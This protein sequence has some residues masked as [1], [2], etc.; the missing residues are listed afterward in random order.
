MPGLASALHAAGATDHAVRLTAATESLRQRTGHWHL[1][2]ARRHLHQRTI[3][4]ARRNLGDDR[5]RQ[6]W[7][8][9]AELTYQELIHASTASAGS[10]TP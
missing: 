5:F 2:P 1:L 7:T 9:G 3:A 8:D 10:R 6:A 4:N